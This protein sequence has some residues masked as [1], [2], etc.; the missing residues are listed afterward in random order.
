MQTYQ[1]GDEIDINGTVITLGRRK[2]TT[3]IRWTWIAS[4]LDVTGTAYYSTPEDAIDNA[5]RALGAER[6]TCGSVAEMNFGTQ[7][8]CGNCA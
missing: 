2:G 5:R 7:P 1:A 4:D 3:G 8:V 6:C